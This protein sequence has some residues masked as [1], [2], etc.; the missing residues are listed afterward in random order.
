MQQYKST[1]GGEV[2][3]YWNEFEATCGGCLDKEKSRSYAHRRMS[4]TILMSEG[5][6]SVAGPE[7]WYSASQDTNYE[8]YDWKSSLSSR[9][10]AVPLSKRVK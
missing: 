7:P 5:R 2:L 3:D 4:A 9:Q 6:S 8:T 10:L 1:G